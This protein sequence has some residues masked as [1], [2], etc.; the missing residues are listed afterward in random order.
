MTNLNQPRNG[1]DPAFPL[2]DDEMN[3]KQSGLTK[4]EEFAKA[5]MQGLASKEGNANAEFDTK[6]AVEY[7]D[8]LIVALN[9]EVS[10]G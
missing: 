1:E 5:A 10:N 3:T 9:K 7:A 2:W 6:L 8:A 4:R